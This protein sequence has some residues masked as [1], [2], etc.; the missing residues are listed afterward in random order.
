MRII[1]L[2]SAAGGGFPQWNCNCSNCRRARSGD[3]AA[4]PRTQC[5]LAVS[6]DGRD[7]FL[8]NAAPDLR[9]QILA[10]RALDPADGL[11]HSPIAGVVLA[12]GEIDAVAGLLTLRE[13]QPFTLYA[14]QRTLDLL[15]GSRMFD[16]LAA[17]CVERRALPL[18]RPAALD[19][20][21]GRAGLEVELF[22]VPG[23]IPLYMEDRTTTPRLDVAGE[24]T[25]GIRVGDGRRTLFFIPGCATLTPELARRLAGADLLLFDGTLW[26]DDEM[27]RL[28]L[29]AK[30]GRRMGHMS[31]G[32]PEGSPAALS[33]IAGQ[34][35]IY[36]HL[37]NSNPVLIEDSPERAAVLAAGW[38]VA[39]DG[40]EILL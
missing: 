2:G 27:I 36:I 31:I 21:A 14:T 26:R 1:V 6:A 12:G 30:S 5:S 38:E 13:R 10:T 25:V 4:W 29:G 20:P 19:G 34:R 33:G 28:G 8:L 23:K 22:P 35:R 16:A 37:N 24:D 11:R 32:G 3:P 7:W 18:G 9:Q 39:Q 40:M 15:A 17:D